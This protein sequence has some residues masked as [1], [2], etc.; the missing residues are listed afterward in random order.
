MLGGIIVKSQKRLR[1]YDITIGRMKPGK[2]NSITDVEG[3]RVGNITLDDGRVKTGVTAILPHGGN[4]F[5][6]KVMASSC[7]INGFGKSTGLIQIEEMGT[8]ETPIVL[9]NTLS[10]GTA[11]DTVVEYMLN[12]NDDIGRTTGTVNPV[13]CECNDGFLN[14][15]RER[16]VEKSHVINAITTAG[17]EFEE[18][19]VGAGT[20]MSCLGLKGGVGTSSRVV[21]LDDQEYILGS[22][23]LSNFGAGEELLIN[24]IKAGDRIKSLLSRGYEEVDKGSIIMIIATDI[25][26]SERQLKRVC[27]RAVVGLART[28]SFMGN[29]SGDIAIA[30]TTANKVRHYEEKDIC[31]MKVLNDNKID[32]VFKAA[33]ETIEEAIL[34]S[35]ICAEKTI[36]RD[37]HTKHSLKEFIEDIL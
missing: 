5:L 29:G 4:L 32:S 33:A 26:L 3:V 28:G 13:V 21:V 31:D 22:L 24:G 34:N 37:G 11:F 25:P 1:D 27:K 16:K 18:G 2:L 10:V 7:V 30:F 8:I 19:S 9:T 35:L 17:I 6:E 14:D 23:V 15:I 20:G 36:G 12:H